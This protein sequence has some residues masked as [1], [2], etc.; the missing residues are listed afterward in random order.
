MDEEKMYKVEEC[1]SLPPNYANDKAETMRIN[2]AENI[3]RKNDISEPEAVWGSTNWNDHALK[4]QPK[5]E[6]WEFLS[7]EERVVAAMWIKLSG[8]IENFEAFVAIAK[9]LKE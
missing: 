9:G 4:S 6:N 8:M 5:L 1:H 7:H 3:I 2:L